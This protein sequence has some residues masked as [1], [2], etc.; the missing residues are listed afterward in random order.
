MPVCALSVLG[1]TR[2]K[3]SHPIPALLNKGLRN[4]LLDMYVVNCFVA[5]DIVLP[6]SEIVPLK[7]EA[8]Y[9]LRI[10]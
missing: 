2:E 4:E 5:P 8:N 6:V 7:K 3:Y 10:T 9:A 1:D